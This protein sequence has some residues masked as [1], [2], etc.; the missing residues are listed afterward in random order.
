MSLV[1]TVYAGRD[2][3]LPVS[4]YGPSDLKEDAMAVRK[5][6]STS[7]SA[8]V[9]RGKAEARA[10]LAIR[11]T[12]RRKRARAIAARPLRRRA[13]AKPLRRAIPRKTLT[14]IGR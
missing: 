9:R 2:P 7:A 1:R 11:A 4:Y 8:A 3:A 10:I 5:G 12:K 13:M 14:A 6:R